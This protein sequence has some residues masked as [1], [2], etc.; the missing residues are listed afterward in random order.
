ML[1]L[2]LHQSSAP[3]LDSTSARRV[4]EP[5]TPATG[6]RE[7]RAVERALAPRYEVHRLL[8]R[9]GMGAVY[10]AEERALR[11][12]VA[13]KVL[14][15]AFAEGPTWRERF[16]AEARVM[17]G[18][19]HPGVIPVHAYGEQEG[20]LWYVMPFVRG[21]S[22]GARLRRE[23]TLHPD[24][25]RRILA[26]IADALDYVHRRGV[27]HRDV[28]PDNILLEQ[29][30]GRAVLVDFGIAADP[31]VHERSADHAAVGTPWYMSP[32][33]VAADAVLDGRSDVY[34]LG[35][36]GYLA[37]S[38]RLPFEGTTFEEIAAQ[39]LSREPV[40]LRKLAPRAPRDLAEAITRCLAKEPGERWPDAR[41]FARSVSR[42]RV[43]LRAR[44]RA[45]IAAAFQATS[46]AL[47]YALE[48]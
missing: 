1:P 9:G 42:E 37:L 12:R 6:L 31:I 48:G 39:H 20:V 25:A 7:R 46:R 38:G 29:E 35:V 41:T 22:L 18:L 17:A 34:A 27:V 10:L 30:T 32:E 2:R 40:P 4:R 16:R 24:D 8:A 23:G 45:A 36:L 28:K 19:A 43:S 47:R 21:E 33:Q 3:R 5:A 15:P 11:R 14:D 26:D 13:I 44:L